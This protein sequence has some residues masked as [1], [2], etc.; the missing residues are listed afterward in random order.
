MEAH[1]TDILAMIVNKSK[2][3]V[4]SRLVKLLVCNTKFW[5]ILSGGGSLFNGSYSLQ[6]RAWFKPPLLHTHVRVQPNYAE[7]V[8]D[9]SFTC[10]GVAA[11]VLE[12][13]L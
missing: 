1:P 2:K 9:S 8:H 3:L 4:S 11:L 5:S 12:L 10:S 13:L 7:N 6:I